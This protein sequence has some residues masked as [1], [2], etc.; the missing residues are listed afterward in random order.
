M[1]AVTKDGDKNST[2]GSG[3]AG[4]KISTFFKDTLKKPAPIVSTG[5]GGA[6]MFVSFP[7]SL[8][9]SAHDGCGRVG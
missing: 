3:S 6:G 8:S 1:A 9:F 5:R 7:S 4:S 2:S